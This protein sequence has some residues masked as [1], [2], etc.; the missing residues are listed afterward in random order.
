[1]R[2]DKVVEVENGAA[3]ALV[4]AVDVAQDDWAVLRPQDRA[5]TVFVQVVDTA[6]RTR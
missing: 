3:E 1:V 6:R 5:A 4:G 2:W